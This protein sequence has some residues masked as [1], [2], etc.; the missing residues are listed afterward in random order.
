MNLATIIDVAKKANVSKSTV[1]RVLT[2]NGYVSE[3]SREKVL[4]A[5]DEIG[6]IPN[7]LARQLQSGVTKTIG[8][9]APNY[10]NSMGKFLQVFMESAKNNGYFVNLYLT[11]GDKQKEIEALNQLKYKQVDGI[12]I[13]T[14]TNEWEVIKPYSQYGPIA[15]WNRI[16][17]EWIYSSYVDHYEGYMMALKH[18]YLLG[19]RKIGHVLGYGEN[20]NTK[21]RVKAL[22]EFH[23][24]NE[25]PLENEWL[26]Q[27]NFSKNGGR[28]IA[29]KWEKCP[30]K[31]EVF[32]FY[33]DQMAAEFISEIELLGYSCPE[34]IAV[35]GFDNSEV[36][37]LMHISTVDYALERQ[38][39]NS[40]A[41][42]YNKLNTDRLEIH[43]LPIRLIER[44]TLHN[45]QEEV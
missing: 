33:S 32:A 12:F 36:S 40:F 45:Q 41:Y 24:V 8:F 11:G 5:M 20:L 19:Y 14:R 31:P 38:A 13:L 16:E 34:D 22:N 2:N 29:R 21:A 28:K 17:E 15:T 25:L 7:L 30:N 6:Y 42:I 3:N 9:I 10:M 39:A 26:F 37:E 27:S 18:L 44:K 23:Q 1:S 43:S 35:L 4:K